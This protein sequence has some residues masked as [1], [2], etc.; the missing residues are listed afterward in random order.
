MG[1]SSEQTAAET[2]DN[3]PNPV[4][5][6]VAGEP[7]EGCTVDGNNRIS[8]L[9]PRSTITKT[10]EVDMVL[11]SPAEDCFGEAVRAP[12]RE[13][14]AAGRSACVYSLGAEKSGKSATVRG[15]EG[16]AIRISRSQ[17]V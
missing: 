9:R 4:C 12:L 3:A 10:F 7:S 17:W 2:M 8:M 14:L 11:R 1:I 6:L 5:V 13:A 15:D 16:L